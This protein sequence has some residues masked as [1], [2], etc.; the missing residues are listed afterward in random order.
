SLL[1][2]LRGLPDLL[3]DAFALVANALPLVRLRRT[4]LAD[5]RRRLSD[6]LLGR[7]PY[8]DASRHRHFEGD[9]L[10]SLEFDR[11]REAE[12][13]LQLASVQRRAVADALDLEHALESLG[14]AL[15]RIRDERPRKTVKGLVLA[16]VRRPDEAQR[17]VRDLGADHRRELGDLRPQ[18]ARGGHRAGGDVDLHTVRN[19]DGCIS[20]STHVTTPRKVVRRRRGPCA[21]R[22]PS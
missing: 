22:G 4:D 3:P 7:A 8:D 14:H 19:L 21:R 11:V 2:S 5:V 20:Y 9:S 16:L 1:L 12:L 10:G 17:R 13:Q 15:D 6:R 18:W